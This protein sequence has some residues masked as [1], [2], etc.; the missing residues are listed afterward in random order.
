VVREGILVGW[1]M[2]GGE[3]RPGLL[4]W[5]IESAN[6]QLCWRE[7]GAMA[8]AQIMSVV[9]FFFVLFWE[10]GVNIKTY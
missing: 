10:E 6:I 7:S 2:G 5:L 4:A 1:W 9:L 8:T 3:S